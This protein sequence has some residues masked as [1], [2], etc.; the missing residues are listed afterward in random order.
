MGILTP[1]SADALHFAWPH[2]DT[3]TAP[4][5][6]Q[7]GGGKNSINPIQR[8]NQNRVNGVLGQI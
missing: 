3:R 6:W 5:S 2:I 7:E 4:V 1:L 8:A